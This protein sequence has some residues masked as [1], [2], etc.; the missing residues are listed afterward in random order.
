MEMWVGMLS[1][2]GSSVGSASGPWQ[3][4]SS[5]D[6][7]TWGDTL[8]SNTVCSGHQDRTCGPAYR[9]THTAGVFIPRLEH[10]GKY[11]R[12]R[13]P[14]TTGGYAYTRVIG[15]IKLARPA[16][17]PISLNLHGGHNPPRVGTQLGVA[18]GDLALWQR[19]D[20][21][22]TN[23]ANPSGCEYV[24]STQSYTPAA[25]DLNH[26]LRAYVYYG[27][28]IDGVWTR[29]TTGFTQKVA[30]IQRRSPWQ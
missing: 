14:L 7:I 10:G 6:G 13:V 23:G 1:Y 15:K 16:T 19:C 28:T 3:W 26:Y 21:N 30:D 9:A 29:A 12:A 2:G 24:G 20:T 11:I 25:G 8:V 18:A 5:T 22:G 4:Q 17:N 27:N